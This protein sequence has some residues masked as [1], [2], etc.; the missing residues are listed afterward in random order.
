MCGVR[1]VYVGG[2]FAS[3]NGT[4]ETVFGPGGGGGR[5]LRICLSR[6]V[7]GRVP[8]R[9]CRSLCNPSEETRDTLRDGAAFG[10]AGAPEVQSIEIVQSVGQSGTGSR[11]WGSLVALG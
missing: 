3:H 6:I 8:R 2:S 5:G 4:F 7:A 1:A 9:P 10:G 11:V